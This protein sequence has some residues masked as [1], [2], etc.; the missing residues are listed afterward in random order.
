[1]SLLTKSI[2]DYERDRRHVLAYI[3][4]SVNFQRCVTKIL[5]TRPV[6]MVPA[7]VLK[8]EVKGMPTLMHALTNALAKLVIVLL[9]PILTGPSLPCRVASTC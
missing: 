4:Q 7:D 1:M 8:S 9:K 3:Q 5:L 6:P 2:S